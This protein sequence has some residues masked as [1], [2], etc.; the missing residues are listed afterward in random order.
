M[1]PTRLPTYVVVE[2]GEH[3]GTTYSVLTHAEAGHVPEN[4]R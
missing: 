2:A 3:Q 4:L 1:E